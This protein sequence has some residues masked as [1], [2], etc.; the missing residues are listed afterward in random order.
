[1]SD[2]NYEQQKQ[3]DDLKNSYLIP[4]VFINRNAKLKIFHISQ[5][6][7]RNDYR[8]FNISVASK[9]S[10]GFVRNGHDV[11]NFSYRNFKNKNFI[12]NKKFTK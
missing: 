12:K 1:M 10:K 9:L 5:F 6:D 7:E 3:I 8:L 4:N 11:I 2:I